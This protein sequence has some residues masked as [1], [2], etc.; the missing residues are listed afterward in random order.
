MKAVKTDKTTPYGI[1]KT[2]RRHTHTGTHTYKHS[3]HT[4]TV[5]TLYGD[6]VFVVLWISSGAV[7]L[8][9]VLF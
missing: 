5:V 7:M 2:V 4:C 8:F 3:T 6:I 9:D 1:T